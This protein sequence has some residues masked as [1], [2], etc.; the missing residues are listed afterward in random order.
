MPLNV[1]LRERT[2][3]AIIGLLVVLGLI[4]LALL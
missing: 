3:L 2:T 1:T 4:G